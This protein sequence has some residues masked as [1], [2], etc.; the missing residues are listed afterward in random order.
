MQYFSLIDLLV[1]V[2]YL[3][4]MV[5]IG[6]WLV[7]KH[8]N[9][10]DF[11]LAG[12]SLSTPILVATLVSTYYGL[13][14]LFG[15][16]QLGFT[17]GVVAWFGYA[18]PYYVFYL[19]AAFVLARR[20]GRENFR[21]LPDILDHFYGK[22]TRYVG[23]LAS[24]LYSIPA[25]SIY[26]FGLLGHIVLGWNPIIGML[27]F[28]GIAL[29]YT[30]SGGFW[31]VAITD[32]IQFLLMCVVLAVVVPFAL[33]L[34]GGFDALI[35]NLSPNYFSKMGNL[36][37]WLV[38]V[39]ASTGLTVLVEPTFYQRISAA[40]S[41]RNFRN[42]L[43]ISIFLWAAYDWIITI[44]GMA[45]RVGVLKGIMSGGTPADAALLSIVVASL[46]V[47][48]VGLFFSGI[49]ATEMSTVDSYCLVAGGNIAYDIYRPLVNPKASDRTLI[50]ATRYGTS[51]SWL[52]GFGIAIL[53]DQMLG[54]WVFL[55]TI[56]ISTVLIPVLAGLYIPVVRKPLAGLLG[57]S[58]GL[59]STVIINIIML[60]FG[61]FDSIS[62]T[63]TLSFG[64]YKLIQEYIIYFTLPLAL[65]GFL[66]GLL[67]ENL[68]SRNK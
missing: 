20:L 68:K 66:A 59:S 52:M 39:Y 42:A 55:A 21:S 4:L 2:A 62:K 48:L 15:D 47:G 61:D 46:P 40:K 56:L 34:V 8:Q 1:V 44:L 43:I 23:A 27:V 28:G 11:F 7:K 53:F 67:I 63:L 58:V 33:N 16:S 37:I 64:N 29:V 50:K 22:K 65:I 25:L 12:R 24:I 3:G 54:L 6:A 49:L 35:Q 57:A 19:I 10:D 51:V 31:A 9:F 18:R 26:G 14:V 32:T 45:A 60:V 13:D 41:Y 36:S 38:I 17:D 5:G 30:L